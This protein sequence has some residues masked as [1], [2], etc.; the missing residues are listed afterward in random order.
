M[1]GVTVWSYKPIGLQDPAKGN[2]HL[3]DGRDFLYSGIGCANLDVN[4]H[5]WLYAFSTFGHAITVPYDYWRPWNHHVIGC[6]V[7][8]DDAEFAETGRSMAAYYE[9]GEAWGGR[10][11]ESPKN[12]ARKY[13]QV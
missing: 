9:N 8:H 13:Y 11:W 7:G 1:P 6:G 3:S 12:T 5:D 10:W 4:V 2:I